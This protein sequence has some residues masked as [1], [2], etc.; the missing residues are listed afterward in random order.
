VVNWVEL[1]GGE[2]ETS[3]SQSYMLSED[4]IDHAMGW[5]L[6]IVQDRDG[7]TRCGFEVEPN[8]GADSWVYNPE[9]LQAEPV[10]SAFEAIRELTGISPAAVRFQGLDLPSSEASPAGV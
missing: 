10:H 4:A 2:A 6:W 9:H 3:G 7:S 5:F 8:E 1:L